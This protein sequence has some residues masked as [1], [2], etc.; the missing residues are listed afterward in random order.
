MKYFRLLMSLIIFT[1]F[2]FATAPQDIIKFN[3]HRES[4]I[5][6]KQ[7]QH[8]LLR[9]L[10]KISAPL[11]QSDFDVTYYD[12][13][14][15]FDVDLKQ[16]NGSVEI[17]FQSLRPSLEELSIDFSS[18]MFIDSITGNMSHFT[19]DNNLI[20]IILNTTLASEDHGKIKIYYHGLPISGGFGAFGFDTQDE[21]S[22][23]PIIWSL[24]EPYFAR[25]WWPCKDTPSD[26][27]DSASIK[28]TVPSN[29]YAVSNGSL[30]QIRDN[31]DG[32]RTFHWF[33]S[34]PITT[35]LI[36]VAIS[37]YRIISDYFHYNDDSMQVN[38][39]TYPKDIDNAQNMMA[40]TIDMI[41]FFSD[42]YGLYP[43]INEKYGI[44]QFPWGGGMEHQTVSSQGNF[45]EVLTVHELAHQWFGDMITNA[46][47]HE[48]W[49]NEGFASYSEALYFEYKYGKEYYNTYMTW[50]DRDFSYPIWVDDTTNVSR[51]FDI[52]VYDKAGWFLHMLRYITGDELFFDII[53]TYANDPRFKYG[54]ATTTGFQNV[55][56][57]VSGMDLD[58]FFDSWIFFAGRPNYQI[59]WNSTDSADLYITNILVKQLQY[60][61]NIIFPMPLEFQLQFG[62]YDSTVRVFNDQPEQTYIFTSKFKTTG[63]LFDSGNNILKHVDKIT[64]SSTIEIF[65]TKFLLQQNYPN[66]FNATT[67]IPFDLA[68]KNILSMDIWSINGIKVRELFMDKT[69]NRGTTTVEWDGKNSKG[70][71]LP[72]GI[73][74]CRLSNESGKIIG[75][76]K[77]LLIR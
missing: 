34:H 33:E 17:S 53:K 2:A 22:A 24:S 43:F 20:T 73:Y 36:S 35:Y 31:S 11:N 54:N 59:E 37:E 52:T 65:P 67:H 32:T 56:E 71:E 76:K 39:Y 10:D 40:G 51:I 4:M 57:S 9:H 29:L 74:F 66:P 38:F 14:L 30:I 7:N 15:K 46:N 45:G 13:D 41:E 60:P 25:N 5:E 28:L 55:C 48:I 23:T 62:N 27:A 69:F 16:I 72:S 6:Q 19:H 61:S 75:S 47:W 42:I 68:D 49:L 44:A 1:G 70:T 12:L 3:Q 58:Y 21:E 8:E 63:L 18:N 77:M 50:M 26:K 64:D